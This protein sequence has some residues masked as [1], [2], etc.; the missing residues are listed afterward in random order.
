MNFL[1]P[2]LQGTSGRARYSCYIVKWSDTGQHTVVQDWKSRK[3]EHR[4]QGANRKIDRIRNIVQTL[5]ET[6]EHQ[7]NR[8]IVYKNSYIF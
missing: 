1:E 5:N 6:W 4:T 8:R 3:L 7:N 2:K